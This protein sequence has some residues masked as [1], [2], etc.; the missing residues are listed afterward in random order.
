[1]AYP[2]REICQLIVVRP[3]QGIALRRLCTFSG[4]LL[5][6]MIQPFASLFLFFFVVVVFFFFVASLGKWHKLMAL[7][8]VDK[9]LISS[10]TF[11]LSLLSIK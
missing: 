1:M 4:T 2:H 7:T 6:S 5:S 11:H 3:E 9:S 10:K 8:G